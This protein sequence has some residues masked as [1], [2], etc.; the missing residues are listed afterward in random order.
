VAAACLGG[1]LA[2]AYAPAAGAVSIS[3]LTV[4]LDGSNSAPLFDDSGPVGAEIRRSVG[5]TSSA[6][7]QFI[8]RY[9]AGVYTDAGGNGATSNITTLT[10]SYTISFDVI[11]AVGSNWQLDIDTSRIGARSAVTDG[12]GSSAFA[13]S[14]VTGLV[15]GAGTLTSGSLGLVAI[16]NSAQTNTVNIAFNQTGN[17][18]INGSGNGTVK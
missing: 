8:T 9:Q 11:D 7:M 1:A 2:L 12:G 15:G 4:T 6:A 18:L 16:A 3:N 17:A 5:V 10:A 13:L 14:A